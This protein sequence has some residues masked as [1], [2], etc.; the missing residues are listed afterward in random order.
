MALRYNR[1]E[2]ETNYGFQQ[3]DALSHVD[4]FLDKYAK[5]ASQHYFLDMSYGVM[6]M[7]LTD[8]EEKWLQ[9]RLNHI[10]EASKN[11]NNPRNNELLRG[12]I[13]EELAYEALNIIAQNSGLPFH[14]RPSVCMEGTI[15]GNKGA[16]FILVGD[17][18]KGHQK[19]FGGIDVK[20]Y[21]PTAHRLQESSW[22]PHRNRV[23]DEEYPV[24]TL[25]L[26]GIQVEDENGQRRSMYEH[27]RDVAIPLFLAGKL[28]GILPG[29]APNSRTELLSSIQQR[30]SLGCEEAWKALFPVGTQNNER[31]E[32]LDN[33]LLH[34]DAALGEKK[35]SR[36]TNKFA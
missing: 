21:E 30:F 8:E 20:S 9:D 4:A 27:L 22:L 19:A 35:R 34:M 3:K 33:R 25:F 10:R 24:V 6:L 7:D 15:N 16:D 26:G 5:R 17:T 28:D 12:F 29:I 14:I 1:S 18:T 31:L 32:R 13:L 2:G 11:P 23:L 36:K